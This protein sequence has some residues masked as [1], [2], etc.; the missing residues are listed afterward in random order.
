MFWQERAKPAM[1]FAL[2]RAPTSLEAPRKI[3]T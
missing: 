1:L 2:G 3:I